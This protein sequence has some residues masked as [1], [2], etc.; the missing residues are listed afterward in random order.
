MS[1]SFPRSMVNTLVA[2]PA[3]VLA[4][5]SGAAYGRS[6]PGDLG[7]QSPAATS[8]RTASSST[9][10]PGPV[11]YRHHR[12]QW[13]VYCSADHYGMDDPIVFP[14]ETGMSHMHT[15]Y[16]NTS[17]NGSS[18]VTTLSAHISSC[19]RNMGTS[20]HSAYWV[21][22]LMRKH[23][24]GT[25]S[26]VKSE[27]ILTVYYRRAGGGMGPAVHAI[28]VGLKMIAGN[29]MATS[30]QSLRIIQ[31]D[32]GGGGPATAHIHACPGTPSASLHVSVKFPSCWDGKHLDSANHKSHMAYPRR[33]GVCPADHPVSLPQLTFEVSFPGITGGPEYSLASGGRY[34]MHGDF[35]AD[36]RKRV[37]N[38]LVSSC[39]NVPRECAD[40]NR[41]H[42]WLFRP[43]YDPSP[44]TI[45]LRAFPGSPYYARCRTVHLDFPHGVAASA[46]A[47][48]TQ[49]RQGHARPA[50]GHYARQVYGVN[51]SR[52]DRDSDG[53]ACET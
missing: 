46:T 35:F 40:V 22:S 38:A 12:A 30:D 18:T 15:F 47:A 1:F 13:N 14:D 52:L 41:D 5:L 48:A 4:T 10:T 23:A 37:Q 19:G 53:S 45:D 34:S 11:V 51:A 17:T 27:Q 3:L 49:V 21:P 42:R 16:G 6:A 43:S 7:P 25:T 8:G 28:P 50:Y 24:D 39:L 36:W 29:S 26:V 32:C 20:D 44:I 2:A 31:W 33:H 9:R